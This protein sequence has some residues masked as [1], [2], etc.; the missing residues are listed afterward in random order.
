MKKHQKS[1]GKNDEW[2]TPP[3]ILSKLCSFDL[4]PCA[5]INSPFETAKNIYTINDDGL[6]KEW[7]GRIWLNPPFNRYQR[8]KWMKKMAEHNNGIM[9]I[10]AALETDNAFKYVWGK[11]AGIL[12]LEGRPHFHYI[13]GQKAK[14]NS[15]C[16]ICLVAYGRENLNILM[17][18][19]LGKVVVEYY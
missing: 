19:D 10:P 1:I 3:E 7:K 12:F 13:N 17:L 4:D 18:S 16:T 9:L 2:L 15:G 5:A 11:C 8:G 14:A 6:S